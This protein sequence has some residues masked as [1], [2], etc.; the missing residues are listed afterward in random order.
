MQSPTT[1]Y[2]GNKELY[3]YYPRHRC[4]NFTILHWH[5]AYSRDFKLNEPLI[6]HLNSLNE[7]RW[8]PLM[9]L[10]ANSRGR[11]H[12]IPQFISAGANL[13]IQSITGETALML[14]SATSNTSSTENTVMLL[15]DAGAQLNIQNN[16][17]Y[18]ALIAA[19]ES[20][21]TT[22]TENTVKMLINAD[23]DSGS[24]TLLN[25]RN[26]FGNTALILASI[27]SNST[28]TE[29]TVMQLIDAGADLNIGV[30]GKNDVK[31]TA[32]FL[33]TEFLNK[34][35]SENTVKMLVDAGAELPKD[36]EKQLI[37]QK[38]ISK[39]EI[40]KL[41]TRIKE[42]EEENLELKLS[43]NPGPLYLAHKE[44]FEKMQKN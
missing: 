38:I 25:I 24:N 36:T 22:S 34:T 37:I 32:L 29:N 2:K 17:K 9:I 8:T 5:C 27:H 43:P 20:S 35:S 16:N 28:S 3:E 44:Q 15:I 26:I 1:E 13:N 41:Q 33:A 14:A 21:N 18:T 7:E 6:A 30:D 40:E 31:L 11:E 12:L 23:V 39:L 42:L 4:K 19:S 10:C